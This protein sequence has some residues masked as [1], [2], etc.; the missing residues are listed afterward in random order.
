MPAKQPGRLA[1]GAVS[2]RGPVLKNSGAWQPGPGPPAL[3]PVFPHCGK[4][5][6]SGGW[7]APG[8]DQQPAAPGAAI[9]NP[10]RRGRFEGQGT[11]GL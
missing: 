10:A 9:C 4:Q 2:S 6:V 8:S 11:E 1:P 5:T 3:A 7:P